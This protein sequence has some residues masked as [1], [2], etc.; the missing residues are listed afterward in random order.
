[1]QWTLFGPHGESTTPSTNKKMP[2]HSKFQ[3]ISINPQ[4]TQKIIMT[5]SKKYEKLEN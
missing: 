2:K 4:K 3:K 5:F 1:M